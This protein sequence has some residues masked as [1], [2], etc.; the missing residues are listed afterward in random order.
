M[1]QSKLQVNLLFRFISGVPVNVMQAK[2]Q[3]I[4]EEIRNIALI[5]NS[6]GFILSYIS[7]MVFSISLALN[8]GKGL[9]VLQKHELQSNRT[10]QI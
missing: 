10:R 4:H 5:E 7:Q 1:S 8:C 6:I 9:N 2:C 3:Q